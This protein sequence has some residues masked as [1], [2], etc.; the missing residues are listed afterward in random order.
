MER[1]QYTDEDAAHALAVLQANKGNAKRTA[2]ELAVP[3]TTLR[4]WAGRA[5]SSTAHPRKVDRAQLRAALDAIAVKW[6]LA[7][8][9]M[10]DLFR[11]GIRNGEKAADLRNLS[12]ASAIATDKAALT[13]G[14]PTNRTES[15]HVVLIAPDALRSASLPVIEGEIVR[16]E[17]E[18]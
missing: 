17:S 9:E 6:S 14:A 13:A 18:R 10:L 5:A 12:L 4:Q 8:D 16:T 11:Q 15:M 2:A 3:R 1:R 7:A